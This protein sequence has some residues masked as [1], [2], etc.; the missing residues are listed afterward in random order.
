MEKKKLLKEF[1]STSIF[2]FNVIVTVPIEIRFLLFNK[3]LIKK[4]KYKK[5]NL[6]IK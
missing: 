3:Y 6:I 4:Y 5:I 2:L 1:E